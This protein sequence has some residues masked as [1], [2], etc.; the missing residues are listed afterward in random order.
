MHGAWSSSPILYIS[1]SQLMFNPQISPK[2]GYPL[3][4][5]SNH[6]KVTFIWESIKTSLFVVNFCSFEISIHS[7]VTPLIS[8]FILLYSSGQHLWLTMAKIPLRSINCF[9][10]PI[11]F[12]CFVPKVDCLGISCNC[13]LMALYLLNICL[14]LYEPNIFW[15]LI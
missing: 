7:Y 14:F 3:W 8:S 12:H 4:V 2:F 15:T 9:L 6:I 13:K 5:V 1:T 11:W 10:Q